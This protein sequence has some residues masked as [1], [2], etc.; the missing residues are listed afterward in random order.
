MK[1]F[2]KENGKEKVFVQIKDLRF[3]DMQDRTP[4]NIKKLIS[5]EKIN[6][7]KQDEYFEFDDKEFIKYLKESYFI[8]DY[9][10][11]NNMTYEQISEEFD[12]NEQNISKIINEKKKLR[13]KKMSSDGLDDAL[14][15]LVY[16]EQSIAGFINE[17]KIEDE[18]KRKI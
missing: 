15:L 7:N 8:L 17:K 13:R 16:Y 2:T 18:R 9:D 10:K 5:F 14:M 11:F 6:V 4:D 1:K 12:K 3:L